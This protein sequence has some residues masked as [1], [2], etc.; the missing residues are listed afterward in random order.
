MAGGKLVK[1]DQGL[2]IEE[3]MF[4]TEVMDRVLDDIILMARAP[5]RRY[6][7]SGDFPSLS[8]DIRVC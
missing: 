7:G 6:K 5:F 3:R 8:D 4:R 2:L 1:R